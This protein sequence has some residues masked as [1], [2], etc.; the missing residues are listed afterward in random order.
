MTELIR[1]LHVDDEPDIREVVL[2]ALEVIGGF[3]VLQADCGEEALRLV[4]DFKP[5]L[6]L[7]DVMM[8]GISGIETLAEA[9]LLAEFR[10]CPGVFLSAKG[11][12][13]EIPDALT[14]VLGV[15]PKPFDVGSL[16]NDLREFWQAQYQDC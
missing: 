10:N 3:E 13:L 5:D 6:F 7:L 4:G 2:L 9:H 8:P 11:S 15:I 1:I 12:S 16:S 14:N